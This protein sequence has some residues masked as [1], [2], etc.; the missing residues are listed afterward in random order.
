MGR[1][2]T[3]LLILKPW[4]V[5]LVGV[6]GLVRRLGITKEHVFKV[7]QGRY[8]VYVVCSRTA[9]TKLAGSIRQRGDRGDGRGLTAFLDSLEHEAN[10]MRE[11]TVSDAADVERHGFQAEVLRL[12]RMVGRPWHLADLT[13]GDVALV[14]E[15]RHS[16]PARVSWMRAIDTEE[17]LPL[18]LDR[19]TVGALV[20][21][22]A[23]E[24]DDGLVGLRTRLV[25]WLSET[26]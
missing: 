13:Y 7:P 14:T 25:E 9:L 8:A 18:L 4:A 23:G 6:M 20:E 24:R 16:S 12:E 26:E 19:W 2:W 21:V 22:L 17:S 5:G 1:R 10:G 15:W 11:R 3:V